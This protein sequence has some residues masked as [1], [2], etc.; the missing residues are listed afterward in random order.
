MLESLHDLSKQLEAYGKRLHVVKGHSL[1]NLERVCE[2]WNVKKL[3]YLVDRDI[4]SH[5][6]EE[7]VDNLVKSMNIEV[8]KMNLFGANLAPH[9]RGIIYDAISC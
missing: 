1:L 4:G 3:Y 5:V 8:S 7:A 6:M 9:R 2:K